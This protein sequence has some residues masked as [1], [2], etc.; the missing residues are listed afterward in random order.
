MASDECDSKN[1][2]AS[3]KSSVPARRGYRIPKR[4]FMVLGMFLLAVLLYV[5]RACISSS[6]ASIV[7]ELGLT[8]KQMGW[9]FSIFALSY[10]LFQRYSFR[11][12]RTAVDLERRGDFLVDLHGLDGLGPRLHIHA[13]ISLFVRGRR[14]WSLSRMRAGGLFLG[15]HV[16]ARGRA[17]SDV[18][19][20][21][22]RPG[23]CAAGGSVDGEQVR[24][25][26]LF[27]GSGTHRHRLGRLLVFLVPKHS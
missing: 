13:G 15:T 27:P 17:G 8:D 1:V 22:I 9:I 18:F 2:E 23:I 14:S 12:F 6:K 24:L 26:D 16:G 7:A 11:P 5:D 3:A 19:G 4:Y 20:R 10:A 25:A 21:A